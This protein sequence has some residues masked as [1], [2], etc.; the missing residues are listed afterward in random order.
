MFS[1]KAFLFWLVPSGDAPPTGIPRASRP[2][3]ASKPPQPASYDQLI[4]GTE[5]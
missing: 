3:F 5:T 2:L 4:N 1:V